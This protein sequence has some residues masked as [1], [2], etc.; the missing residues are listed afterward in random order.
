MNKKQLIQ[1]LKDRIAH[2]EECVAHHEKRHGEYVAKR[3]GVISSMD[4]EM[5]D[6]HKGKIAAFALAMKMV[7]ELEDA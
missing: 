3:P 4:S 7:K 1:N 2:N 6:W 5:A